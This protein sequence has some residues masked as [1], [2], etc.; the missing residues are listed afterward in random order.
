M[1][2]SPTESGGYSLYAM[3]RLALALF[4]G[5]VMLVDVSAAHARPLVAILA[6]NDGTEVTDFLVPYGVIAG[7]GAADVFAVSTAEGPVALWPGLTIVADTTIDAFDQTH[8]EGADFVIVPAFHD[9]D[10][11]VSRRWLQTQ[12]RKKATA[13]VS[14]CDGALA[15]SLAPDCSTGTAQPGTS[16]PP[17][18]GGSSFLR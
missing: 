16:T 13:P 10:N 4:S 6:Q 1:S 17:S 12:A 2:L 8:P 15:L 9:A 18:S 14:I 11:A 7:S 3:T 5:V